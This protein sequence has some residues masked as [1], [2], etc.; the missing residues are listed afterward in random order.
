MIK[1]L[2]TRALIMNNTNCQIVLVG[3][4]SFKLTLSIDKEIIHKI[5]FVTEK[6]KLS[7]TEE[8]LN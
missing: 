5:I 6:E 3:H 1:R 2:L 7:G 4:S 8:A